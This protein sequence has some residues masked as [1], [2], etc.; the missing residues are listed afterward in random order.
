MTIPPDSKATPSLS[1]ALVTQT[2]YGCKL[3]KAAIDKLVAVAADGIATPRVEYATSSGGTHLRSDS[4]EG[5]R[6]AADVCLHPAEPRRLDTLDLRIG[7]GSRQVQIRIGEQAASVTVEDNEAAWA[8][9]RAEQLRKLLIRADGHS[10]LRRLDAGR[11]A[12]GAGAFAAVAIVVL[13]GT[14][15]LD[16]TNNVLMLAGLSVALVTAVG[17]LAGRWQ[18]RRSHTLIWVAGPRPRRGWTSWNINERMAVLTLLL[19]LGSL[20]LT[21]LR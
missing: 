12:L 16:A 21:L 1:A 9:G 7:G 20:C 18:A 19:G 4:L 17:F 2:V 6:Q 8:I 10:R 14:G 13:I 11:A 15:R 3:D 5:L